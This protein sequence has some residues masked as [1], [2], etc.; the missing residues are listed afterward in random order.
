M[1]VHDIIIAVICTI[2]IFGIFYHVG[3]TIDD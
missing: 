2:I 1:I 3:N